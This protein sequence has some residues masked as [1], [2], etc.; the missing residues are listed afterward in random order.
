[1]AYLEQQAL[2]W[3]HLGELDAVLHAVN[4]EWATANL[5]IDLCYTSSIALSLHRLLLGL[6]YAVKLHAETG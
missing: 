1:V 3:T 2:V 6:G 5:S 4:A